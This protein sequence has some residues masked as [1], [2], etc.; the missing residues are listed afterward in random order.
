MTTPSEETDTELR[1]WQAPTLQTLGGVQGTSGGTGSVRT[2][3]TATP[4]ATGKFSQTTEQ[5]SA[6]GPGVAGAS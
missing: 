4:S 1:R 5:L 2:N 3:E 6:L